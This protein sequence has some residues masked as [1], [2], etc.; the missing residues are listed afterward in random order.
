M[1]YNIEMT[2]YV[3]KNMILLH[4]NLNNCTGRRWLGSSMP[5]GV[6][7]GMDGPCLKTGSKPGLNFEDA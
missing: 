2:N 3:N 4:Y 7:A 6:D 1:C 5:T